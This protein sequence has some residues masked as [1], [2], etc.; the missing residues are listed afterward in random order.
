MANPTVDFPAQIQSPGG[1]AS[2][3][4][5][6]NT[7]VRGRTG[8]VATI[9]DSVTFSSGSGVWTVPNVRTRVGGIPMISATSV[10][11]Y[12]GSP[13]NGPLSVVAADTRVR[14]R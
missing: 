5:G 8:P 4:A 14:S 13:S 7:K 11:A 10:G 9:V 12:T 3:V 1:A 6:P 2:S